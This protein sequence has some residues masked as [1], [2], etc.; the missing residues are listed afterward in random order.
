MT[1]E[2][3]A[4]LGIGKRFGGSRVLDNVSLEIAPGEIVALLGPSG[5]GKTTT[6]R[7][8][9]GLEVPDEGRITIGTRVVFDAHQRLVVP[10]EKRNVGMM[11][12]SYAIWPHMTI[13]ENVAYG[14]RVQGVASREIEQRVHEGLQ[15]VNLGGKA[16]RFPAT[17]SGGEQ[18]RVALARSMV[19][20]PTVL[21]MDEP[22]SN[23]DLKL[24]ERMRLE[25]REVLK[26]LGVTAVYVTHDQTDAMVLADR[27]VIM[28][29]GKVVE[30]GEPR[31]VYERPTT[32]FSSEFLGSANIVD[33]VEV[34]EKGG[35]HF[36]R[37][38]D[39][40]LLRLA[41]QPRGLRHIIRP[42][43]IQ[44]SENAADIGANALDGAITQ[45]VYM[46]NLTYHTVKTGDLTLTVQTT[47][48]GFAVGEQ[49][50]AV[51]P[52]AALVSV[53]MD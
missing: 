53:S 27:L 2:G 29:A 39:G 44:L 47:G 11:F 46:G 3:V 9:A 15:A 19:T 25:L 48:G 34:V 33:F 7:C 10:T 45:S 37:L 51:V 38:R 16:S 31:A 5:C 6:L 17:L 50:R 30:A 52:V 14:L 18:Q 35:G 40:R 4:V 22:L 32:Q 26:R 28:N 24:R 1:T 12:Q 8:L 49:V 21:L 13:F 23:L 42:E 20:H 36:G 41:G 43:R